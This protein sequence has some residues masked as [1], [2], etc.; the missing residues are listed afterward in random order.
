MDMGF[1]KGG[2]PYGTLVPTCTCIRSMSF[3]PAR[4]IDR[5]SCGSS[6][7]PCRFLYGSHGLYKA[8]V[9]N[10]WVSHKLKLSLCRGF[11]RVYK[12]ELS[13]SWKLRRT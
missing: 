13:R 7:C 3:G 8:Y 12:V 11:M 5:S 2:G 4:K 6:Y 10:I 9:G 1:H